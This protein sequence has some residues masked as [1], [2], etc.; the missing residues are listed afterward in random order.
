MPWIDMQDSMRSAG[1][2]AKMIELATKTLG[3]IKQTENH[4]ATSTLSNE[5]RE[6]SKQ[7][8]QILIRRLDDS[9]RLASDLGVSNLLEQELSQLNNGRPVPA[10]ITID[11]TRGQMN[12]TANATPQDLTALRQAAAAAMAVPTNTNTNTY[13]PFAPD[14]KASILPNPTQSYG[15]GTSTTGAPVAN[16]A[17]WYGGG[18]VHHPH[19]SRQDG[20]HRP[21]SG[22][23]MAYD[24]Y[25]TIN[26]EGD[27]TSQLQ[28]ALARAAAAATMAF[29]QHMYAVFF[30]GIGGTF[31]DS[32]RPHR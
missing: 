12:A 23:A 29:A 24:V 25:R 13:R 18:P 19:F 5:A 1:Q 30:S 16:T 8:L 10:T 17:A 15:T 6:E 20:M 26:H 32:N 21:I 4:L 28:Q 31:Y 27:M 2:V 9:R 11:S 7:H 22:D 3:Q 14:V